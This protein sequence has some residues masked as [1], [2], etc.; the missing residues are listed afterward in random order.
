MSG[1]MVLLLVLGMPWL[2]AE[3]PPVRVESHVPIEALTQGTTAHWFG[4]YDKHQFDPADRYV[5]GMAVDFEGRMP[6]PEDVVVLGYIDREAGNRWT[7]FGESRAWSWQQGCMLQWLPGSD[8]EVIYNDRDGT[9]FIAVVQNVFTGE[10]RVLPRAI[11]TVA[12]DGKHGLSINF[13][14]ID[15]TRPGY[16]YKGGIDPEADRLIPEDDGIFLLD[17]TTGEDKRI[18]DYADFT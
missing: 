18:L 1:R 16:G 14:R 10:K 5:L 11:Y 7:A 17:L 12:A 2:Q 9:Q 15:D 13:A 6:A 3:E 4:Y 8:S